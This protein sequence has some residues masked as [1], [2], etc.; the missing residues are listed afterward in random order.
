MWN[1]LYDMARQQ[2]LLGVVFYGIQKYRDIRIE[3]P[4]LLQWFSVNEQILFQNK[5]VDRAAVALSSFLNDRGFEACVLKGQGNTLN[6]PNPYIRMSGD[7]DVWVRPKRVEGVRDCKVL[8]QIEA[9]ISL[10][11]TYKQDARPTYHHVDFREVNGVE[12]EL[13]YRPSF[14]NNPV[15]NRRLQRWFAE[16]QD[17]QFAHSVVLPDGAG[18]I[19]VPTHAFNRIFQMAHISNHFFHEG[20]G[21]RQ[22]L[23]YYYV[24]Q[25]GFTEEEREQD[26]KLLRRFGLYN[27]AAAVM[28]VLQKAFGLLQ[29]HMLVA[30]DEKRGRFLLNEIIQGGNFG[31]Y[32]KR[33]KNHHSQR[34]RNIQRLKRDARLMWL[35][36]SECIWEPIFRVWHYFWR[37][38]KR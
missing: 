6:Y 2:S 35:F 23:D 34:G 13:H 8:Q 30:T 33:T 17:V 20:I 18:A 15:H 9:V 29:E 37:L 3:R 7:I 25:Q 5:K 11:R 27:V 22:L 31:Q 1:D 12:V 32:D 38:W 36:P 26:E 14:M 16:Q 10:A 21:L 19:Q 28:Y 4:L 24:L